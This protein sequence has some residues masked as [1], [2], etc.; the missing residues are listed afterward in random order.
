MISAAIFL[1]IVA[2]VIGCMKSNT[3]EVNAWD[4]V[5]TAG[6]LTIVGGVVILCIKVMP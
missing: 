6:A 5:S 2:F 1:G 4:Y 3:P